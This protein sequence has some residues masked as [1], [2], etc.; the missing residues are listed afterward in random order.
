MTETDPAF[1]EWMEP[2]T[3]VEGDEWPV[4]V[5]DPTLDNAPSLGKGGGFHSEGYQSHA[6]YVP[7][8]RWCW[9]VGSELRD[10]S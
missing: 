1:L 9:S 6:S 2:R 10:R 8:P 3:G 5:G 4:P 7:A